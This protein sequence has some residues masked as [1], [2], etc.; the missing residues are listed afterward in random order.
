M[1][2]GGRALRRVHG[3]APTPAQA[4]ERASTAPSASTRRP[5]ATRSRRSAAPRVQAS[6]ELHSVTTNVTPHT[7]VSDATW[8][9]GITE[10]CDAPAFPTGT[11]ETPSTA[12]SRRRSTPP[13]KTRNASCPA[14]RKTRRVTAMNGM[15][16]RAVTTRHELQRQQVERAQPVVGDHGLEHAGERPVEDP[17]P[18]A[19]PRQTEQQRAPG[20]TSPGRERPRYGG[21][22]ETPARS[23]RRTASARGRAHAST[24]TARRGVSAAWQPDSDVPA[25]VEQREAGGSAATPRAA[26]A[27]CWAQ[28][29]GSRARS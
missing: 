4:R 8:M 25:G 1:R 23:G 18:Q 10:Y 19:A 26:P 6:T 24:S 9:S 27:C 21:R 17:P 3:R 29:G 2:A 11:R 7:P 12:A 14:R 20:R 22:R 5:A 15:Y 16:S 28:D 13:G